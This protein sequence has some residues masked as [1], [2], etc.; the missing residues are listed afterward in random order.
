MTTWHLFIS[1]GC[2]FSSLT[3]LFLF[4]SSIC[5]LCCSHR[6]FGWEG[7]CVNCVD[8]CD[9]A[10]AWGVY[11][12]K[13]A[14]HMWA[15]PAGVF[16]DRQPFLHPCVSTSPWASTSSFWC[17]LCEIWPPFICCVNP[18]W[19]AAAVVSSSL[20]G[21]N[22]SFCA[23]LSISVFAASAP[24]PVVPPPVR[25]SIPRWENRNGKGAAGQPADKRKN[26]GHAWCFQLSVFVRPWCGCV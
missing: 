16:M 4:L 9:R 1:S 11:L 25:L 3:G 26:A 7:V 6:H 12:C 17:S 2:L 10:C 20:I 14:C 22:P 13:S 15:A 24:T 21:F 18:P 19:I 23:S 5:N 8:W